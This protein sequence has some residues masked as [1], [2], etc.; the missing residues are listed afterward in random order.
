MAKL[1][2]PDAFPL[3]VW[4]G[5][6]SE[7][8]ASV[9]EIGTDDMPALYEAL[10]IDPPADDRTEGDDVDD[11]DIPSVDVSAASLGVTFAQK[12]I[13]DK[14]LNAD[15][16]TFVKASHT[17]ARGPFIIL[18]HLRRIYT[19]DELD[20]VPVPGTGTKTNPVKG[21]GRP[22]YY[23]RPDGKG[24]TIK[25]YY[26]ADAAA[27]L[28]LG[29]SLR[30]E[31]DAIK[32][33]LVDGKG[34]RADLALKG[35]PELEVILGGINN[36]INNHLK[37][38]RR[39]IACHHQMVAIN[40]LPGVTCGITMARRKVNGKDAMVEVTEGTQVF[41]IRHATFQDTL[42]PVTVNA[43]LRYDPQLAANPPADWEVEAGSYDALIKTAKRAAE[44]PEDGTAEIKGVQMAESYFSRVLNYVEQQ[45][46]ASAMFKAMKDGKHDTLLQTFGD[47]MVWTEQNKAEWLK[48]RPRYNKLTETTSAADAA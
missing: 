12:M 21:N 34:T 15:L 5:L 26:T 19:A 9:I 35:K 7:D 33:A 27:A 41:T 23:E 32:I 18:K 42:K 30:D 13:G 37:V 39:A 2:R 10:G 17:V 20:N 29:K 8:K 11:K 22:D 25:G 24:G 3:L 45:D 31:R 48:L 46:A 40:L 6:S 36:R 14:E 1:V 28:P 44:T 4:D 47:L 38:L 16:D 43:L